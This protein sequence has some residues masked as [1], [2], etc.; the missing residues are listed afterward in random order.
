LKTLAELLSEN[1][2]RTFGAIGSYVLASEFGIA[3]GFES[4]QEDF[5]ES[6]GD[7]PAAELQKPASE[8]TSLFLDWFN[9]N[10]QERFFAFL[11]FYDPHMPRPNGYD[12]EVTQVD[13][14]VGKILE[15][16]SERNLL[17]QTHVLVLSDHGE[18]LGEHGEQGHGYFLYDSTL[19]V[20]LIIRPASTTKFLPDRIKS[21]VSLVDIFPTVM[22]LA[23]LPKQEFLQ[24]RS[25]IDAL[26]GKD[27][28]EVPLYAE[29]YIPLF[30]VGAR[31]L[32]SIRFDQFKYI[33]SVRPELYNLENDPSESA[34]IISENRDR[35]KNYGEKLKQFQK[36]KQTG[37]V[38]PQKDLDQ[39]AL[40]RLAALGYLKIS[41]SS[42]GS[43]ESSIDAKDRIEIFE[44]YHAL[45]NSLGGPDASAEILTRINR[46]RDKAPDLK[47]LTF[48]EA[49]VL[50]NL[51]RLAESEQKYQLAFSEDTRNNLA[52]ARRG[53]VLI[54]M[55]N[56]QEAE[57]V[58]VFLLTRNPDDYRSRNNLAGI[59]Q[60]SGRL[61]EALRELE[62]IVESNPDYAAAWNN[63]GQMHGMAGRWNEAEK[64]FRRVISIDPGDSLSHYRLAFVLKATGRLSEAN[65]EMEKA[66]KL[67]PALKKPANW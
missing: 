55:K 8:V 28:L 27:L 36:E 41:V 67:N 35:A 3:Q 34:N 20:P 24:G 26:G 7:Q 64:A 18:S 33:D 58:L 32:T 17:N 12:W 51:G 21:Q 50:E 53:R 59:Y 9:Q 4:Y 1:R 45:V 29:S 60:V 10:H 14:A 62:K 5:G 47:G 61:D 39:G 6:G 43:K 15:A 48:Y 16:L 37:S 38:D 44:E 57:E 30:H 65:L 63:L 52:L 13:E 56:F 25:L 23:G 46:L 40:D 66:I 2:Y 31:P 54:N 42:S 11:H 19:H 22:D 49:Q